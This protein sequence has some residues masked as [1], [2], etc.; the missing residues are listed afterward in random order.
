MLT[1]QYSVQES[2]TGPDERESND[3]KEIFLTLFVG[4]YLMLGHIETIW[5]ITVINNLDGKTW[6]E[7]FHCAIYQWYILTPS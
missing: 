1:V 7:P 5:K 6:Y 4:I 2:L 3:N